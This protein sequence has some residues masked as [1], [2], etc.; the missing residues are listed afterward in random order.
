MNIQGEV[1]REKSRRRCFTHCVRMGNTRGGGKR[2]GKGSL[3]R[4]LLDQGVPAKIMAAMISIIILFN[5][6]LNPSVFAHAMTL[7]IAEYDQYIN[8][9]V[10]DAYLEPNDPKRLG[11]RAAG[12]KGTVGGTNGVETRNR[13]WKNTYETL[14][15]NKKIEKI[16]YIHIIIC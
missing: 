16:N 15:R 6:I 11:G 1:T 10:R 13:V 14:V 7:F 2:G 4:Y 3:P 12:R 9:H 8:Q 5:S